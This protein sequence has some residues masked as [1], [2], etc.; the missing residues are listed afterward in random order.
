MGAVKTCPEC[1]E[2][3]KRIAQH[4]AYNESHRPE[5]TE[6]QLDIAT[7]VLMGDGCIKV[8]SRKGHYANFQ[9]EMITK[10]YLEWLSDIFGVLSRGVRLK[11][12]AEQ[13]V[14]RNIAREFDENASL[15]T[16]NDSYCLETTTHPRFSE[17]RNW[18]EDGEKTFPYNIELNPT[19]LK[20]WYVC[21]GSLHQGRDI[22]I[23]MSNER[24]NGEKIERYFSEQ[25]LPT[26]RWEEH[27]RKGGSGGINYRARW[28]KE[29][30]LELFE[31][32]GEP[33]PGFEYK[34]PDNE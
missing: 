5:L 9:I 15:D 4:W 32:M 12:T 33:L 7:G 19:V 1:G 6:R 34:W 10:P 26:P 13:H 16:Y 30:S 20:H 17:L 29:E 11:R 3:Y 14:E 24:G 27:G 25:S 18:Y 22:K 2:V 31:Y 28:T 21:D 8:D 23:A